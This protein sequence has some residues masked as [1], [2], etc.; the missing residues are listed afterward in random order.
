[1]RRHGRL[2]VFLAIAVLAAG[3]AIARGGRPQ[4]SLVVGLLGLSA[5]SLEV[6]A[7]RLP[8]FGFLSSSFPCA[9][10]I[11]V[12]PTAGPAAAACVILLSLLIRALLRHRPNS[13]VTVQETVAD[14]VPSLCA[15]ASAVVLTPLSQKGAG[16]FPGGYLATF[17]PLLVFL[18]LGH[19][20]HRF[21]AFEV[22]DLTPEIWTKI[23]AALH[24][25]IRVSA[26]AAP[27]LVLLAAQSPWHTLWMAPLFFGVYLFLNDR[28]EEVRTVRGREKRT[29]HSL[30]QTKKQLTVT[31]TTLRGSQKEKNLVRRCSRLFAQ[32]GS[33][34]ET[35]NAL[36]ML[37]T[38]AAGVEHLS[39]YL[40]RDRSLIL[41]H[42]QGSVDRHRAVE[43]CWKSGEFAAADGNTVKAFPLGRLGV[44]L[45]SDPQSRLDEGRV[46]LLSVIA[47]QAGLGIQSAQRQEALQQALGEVEISNQR[48]SHWIE[49]LYDMLVGSRAMT[50]SFE[51]AQVLETLQGMLQKLVP[52]RWGLICMASQ[53]LPLK[54]CP[55]RE[56][57]LEISSAVRRNGQTLLVSRFTE[58]GPPRLAP[59]Q[60]AVLAAPLRSENEVLGAIVLASPEVDGFSE[61]HRQVLGMLGL[62]TAVVLSNCQ[63]YRDVVQARQNLEESQAHLVQS[64]KMA[65]VGQLAAGVAHEV[66]TP[67]GALLL[68][69][70]SA[71]RSLDK[72]R[73][74]KVREK[75]Q[76]C[77]KRTNSAKDV[78]AKLLF[79]SREGS[80]E[81]RP[82]DLND[83][84]DDTLSFLSQQLEEGGVVLDWE[85]SA[86]PKV[87]ANQNELQQVL[88]NLLLN[89][90]DAALGESASGPVIEVR[91]STA[92][93]QVKLTVS[94]RGGGVDPTTE[95][96]IF[97]PFF[98][99]K[100]VGRG[101]G[102]GLYISR[103]IV[104]RH[105]GQLI[106]ESSSQG[107]TF[108]VLLPQ[109]QGRKGKSRNDAHAKCGT[110]PGA[111]R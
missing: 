26:A 67:L 49:R 63:L 85:R 70:Q 104:E 52:F 6:A 46:R 56:A 83:V 4:D 61:E 80:M 102:L 43:E 62:H 105:Q 11:A 76:Q 40:A 53:E 68:A 36:A 65:A 99:T 106:L 20:C 38:E 60:Q 22:A 103:R 15:V 23:A 47:D 18:I 2:L 98:T 8:H 73:Y 91:L 39:I 21:I 69:L 37:A 19:L 95:S 82:V 42:S 29:R 31:E 75:L 48:L 28:L 71:E 66:N 44:L 59:T 7:I 78:V 88:I 90:R 86:V 107:A 72:Q 13:M 17:G 1:M 77:V 100:P 35:I 108:A 33:L 3:L 109:F 92:S 14:S 93:D 45:I 57:A 54:E 12:L 32:S 64:S 24:I 96:R 34:K 87:E 89:A 41:A 79:Y 110:H 30:S 111:G 84:V 101:T 81:R 94:D 51:T 55:N 50:S 9:F 16:G 25:Q 10:C 74:E 97:E 58:S 27:M 5:L